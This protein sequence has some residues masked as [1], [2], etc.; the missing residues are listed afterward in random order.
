[1]VAGHD[2]AASTTDVLGIV[3]SRPLYGFGRPRQVLAPAGQRPQ[4][5]WRDA[6]VA[7]VGCDLPAGEEDGRGHVGDEA[8]R[9][10][11]EIPP[12]LG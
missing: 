2:R 8:A 7:G 9:V 6:G 3:E 1:M 12:Y 5:A 11:F 10:R 4:W